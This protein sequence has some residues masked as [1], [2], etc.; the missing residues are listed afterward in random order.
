MKIKLI[1]EYKSL[2]VGAVLDNSPEYCQDLIDHEIAVPCDETRQ[3][4]EFDQKS[5][6]LA[7]S[8]GFAQAQ[9]KSAPEAATSTKPYNDFG[10]FL[11]DLANK[12]LNTKN[13]D[14]GTPADGGYMVQTFVEPMPVVSIMKPGSV[15]S[16]ARM[17]TLSGN[18]GVFKYPILTTLAEPGVISEASLITNI[19][20]TVAIKTFTLE[21][22]AQLVYVSQE[23]VED[24][25]ALV[26]TVMAQIPSRFGLA[27]EDGILNGVGTI[28]GIIGDTN[29]SYAVNEEASQTSGTLLPQNIN[30]IFTHQK[31]PG[32]AVWIMSPTAHAQVLSMS[33][34]AGYY[35]LFGKDYSGSVSG[36]LK[37]RPIVI[38]PKLPAVGSAGSIMF[39]DMSQY[40]LVQK[41]GLLANVSYDYQ[42]GYDLVTY[43]FAWR[44]SGNP[45][46]YAY[47]VTDGTKM[48]SFVYLNA[49]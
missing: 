11:K 48:S 17:I 7:I 3:V 10:L 40:A 2:K 22:L 19:A 30:K 44:I 47:T 1:K 28:G 27:I 41:A 34:Q 12:N 6:A 33:T 20:P 24:T 43:R 29:C 37:G 36:L 32:E 15:A 4:V 5:L 21:K 31:N 16:L 39:C 9:K 25:G 8:D 23:A 13:I 14:I 38:S 26:S 35:P 45:V 18:S 49:H 42:F 46:D